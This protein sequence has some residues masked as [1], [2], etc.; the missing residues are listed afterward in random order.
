M[1][2][3]L[4]ARARLTQSGHISRRA[5]GWTRCREH[6]SRGVDSKVGIVRRISAM[7]DVYNRPLP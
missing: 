1:L 5:S 7:E 4:G 2:S 6:V 3:T